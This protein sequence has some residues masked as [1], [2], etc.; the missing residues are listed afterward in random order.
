MVAR[1]LP[2]APTAKQSDEVGQ[3]T[4]CRALVTP[5]VSLDQLDPPVLVATIAPSFPAATQFDEDTQL[6]PLSCCE[7]PEVCEDQ[8]S[9]IAGALASSKTPS[10][11]AIRVIPRPKMFHGR[12]IHASER[13]SFL[14]TPL[15][16]LTL[17]A[18]R[19]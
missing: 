9:A 7:V 18:T 6:T 14:G 2:L 10:T 13:H 19:W 8:V 1:I 4:A 5:E 15:I 3:A 11:T 17:P 12:T 16:S